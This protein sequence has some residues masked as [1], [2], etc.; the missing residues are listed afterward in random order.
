MKAD[1]IST[2]DPIKWEELP[3]TKKLALMIKGAADP[4][5]FWTHPSLGNYK[6][7]PSQEKIIKNFYTKEG[8]KRKYSE[9]I[10]SI[11]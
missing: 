11:F 7:W 9:L 4:I 3:H 5:F 10:F 2:C 8:E 1:I 6:P